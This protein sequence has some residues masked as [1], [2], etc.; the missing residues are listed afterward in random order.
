MVL[1]A[2][3]VSVTSIFFEISLTEELKYL[4]PLLYA[5]K[6]DGIVESH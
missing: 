4:I 5:A 2:S 3:R 1:R 6:V